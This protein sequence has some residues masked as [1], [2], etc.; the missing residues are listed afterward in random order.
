ML[1]KL[2]TIVKVTL[3][4]HSV[5]Y[6]IGKICYDDLSKCQKEHISL[7]VKKEDGH[8]DTFKGSKPKT[9]GKCSKEEVKK[10]EYD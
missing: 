6:S 8:T 10:E 5:F 7:K 9:E 3:M 2:S 1:K 4:D